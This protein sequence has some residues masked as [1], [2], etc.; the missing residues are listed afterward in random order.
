MQI[1]QKPKNNNPNDV[2]EE[3]VMLTRKRS[4]VSTCA[5]KLE[6]ISS[7]LPMIEGGGSSVSSESEDI[8][9]Q[10]EEAEQKLRQ[11]VATLKKGQSV[12]NNEISRCHRNLDIIRSDTKELTLEDPQNQYMAAE[13]ELGKQLR[14]L[15]ERRKSI[16]N[17]LKKAQ[18]ALEIAES[19][20]FPGKTPQRK[21]AAAT[22]PTTADAG[23]RIATVA[24]PVKSPGGIFPMGPK[25]GYPKSGLS[26]ETGDILSIGFLE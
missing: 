8:Y 3:L 2:Q 11:A 4:R 9:A 26:E 16:N 10:K 5:E 24:P 20:K 25:V 14:K 1:I 13:E 17:V 15:M 21:R 18:L 7:H 19:K 23:D 22:P 12:L 6:K